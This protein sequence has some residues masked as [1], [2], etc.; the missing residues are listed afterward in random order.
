LGAG[1]MGVVFQA[2]DPHLERT[3]ALK[4]M[5]PALAVSASSRQRF[6][7]E[8]RTA[9]ALSDD[10]IVPI[11]QVGEDRGIPFIVMP[12]LKGESLESLFAR[13]AVVPLS[14]ALR[15]G[16]EIAQGL[17]AA[18]AHGL[19]HRD[20]KPGNIW[21]ETTPAHAV[22]SQGSRVKILDF[23]LARAAS[24]EL[25]LTQSGAILG[26]PAFMAPEQA[27]GKTVDFRADLFSF[28]CVLYRLVTGRMAFQAGDPVTT[29]VAV[30]TE[31]PRPPAEL[32]PSLPL[33]LS[34]LVMQ[35]LA[36]DPAK[37]PQ[38][39]QAVVDELRAIETKQS[40]IGLAG[41]AGWASQRLQSAWANRR[42]HRSDSRTYQD[43]QPAAALPP[44]APVTPTA[45]P[46]RDWPERAIPRDRLYPPRRK[47]SKLRRI[48]VTLIVLYVSYKIVLLVAGLILAGVKAPVV[49]ESNDPDEHFSVKIGDRKLLEV[50]APGVPRAA[51]KAAESY[52]K[53]HYSKWSIASEEMSEPFRA[54][55]AGTA[56]GKKQSGEFRLHM[57]TDPVKGK[58]EYD[59]VEFEDAKD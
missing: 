9:A 35:L 53:S 19:I 17:A 57:K 23:G 47:R 56:S 18:H 39:A 24:G 55:F 41:L 32:Q 28:G 42:F 1:G 36:K 58:W 31:N 33:A 14:E 30:A 51:R 5:L 46:S 3:V 37:R 43:V 54:V 59:A 10:H 12:L 13:Q 2:E 38:S 40:G 26:T 52:L 49:I 16:R 50:R 8:A 34:R 48:I 21:L 22:N 25:H 4:A 27:S 6:L 7:R 11:Y 15:I 44:A 29:L 20:I 45:Y